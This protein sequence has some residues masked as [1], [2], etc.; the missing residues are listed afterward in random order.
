MSADEELA[1][2]LQAQFDREVAE[3]DVRKSHITQHK[4]AT[5]IH[6]VSDSEDSDYFEKSTEVDK[7]NGSQDLFGPDKSHSSES[8]IYDT[9]TDLE[10][11]TAKTNSTKKKPVC[12]YGA[13]CYRKNPS[14]LE[15]YFHPKSQGKRKFEEDIQKPESSKK[16]KFSMK[17]STEKMP[18]DSFEEFQPFS[19]FLTKVS[20][21]PQRHNAMGAM[22]LRDI[23]SASMGEL[24][25]S[26]HFNFMFEIPWL[27]KQYPEEFRKMPLLLVHGEQGRQELDIKAEADPFSNVS[28]CR[29]PLDIPYGTHHT[30]MMFL[31]YET[32]LRVVIHTA[33]LISNDWYQKTQGIWISPVFPPLKS[34][35]EKGDSPTGFK[36]DLLQ[37]LAAYKAPRLAPWERHIQAHDMSAANVH[38]IG[39]VPGRHTLNNKHHWGHLKLKKVLSE[40][41]PDS[42]LVKNWPVVGQFS[43]IGSLG[44]SKEIWLLNEW[45]QSLSACKKEPSAILPASKLNLIFPSKDNIRLSLEGYNGGGCVPYSIKTASKQPWLTPLFC[46]WVS[47]GRGRSKAVPHIKTYTRCSPDG[48][49]AAW[50]LVTS[51]NLSKAAWGVLEKDRSQLM[52]RS[53]ELGVLFLPQFFGCKNAFKVTSHVEEVPQSKIPIFPLPYDLPPK[54][55]VKGDRPWFVDVP[56]V[57]L[58]DTFG[59]MWCPPL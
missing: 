6:S 25:S 42:G 7:H 35:A 29:A 23:L 52:I 13:R 56:C 37:Y 17:A 8:Y 57:D 1:R 51:A 28:L 33:N 19:F 50:F 41:G 27:L 5:K 39:S 46:Q 44:T 59:T 53:Y 12:Q 36:S 21:I 15:E 26:C 32:G 18:L 34:P 31:L 24:K 10:E 48:S 11:E 20:D 40:R 38:M 22:N 9:D 16:P 30:K 4:L 2:K 45:G 54:T 14:H 49:Q 58:P 47:E 3:Y 43:S 55:Y